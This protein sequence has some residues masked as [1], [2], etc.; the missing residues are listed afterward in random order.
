MAIPFNEAQA[1]S[2][3]DGSAYS[4]KAKPLESPVMESRT[5]LKD[6]SWPNIESNFL[7]SPK[8]G[9]KRSREKR[10]RE[11]NEADKAVGDRKHKTNQGVMPPVPVQHQINTSKL[12]T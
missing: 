2:V 9:V 1:V 8:K 10:E 11:R 5:K 4:Q 7:M 12:R 3:I 6:L